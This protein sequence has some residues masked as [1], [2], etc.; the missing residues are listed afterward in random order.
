[1]D[2][3]GIP[4]GSLSLLGCLL[5]VLGA[6]GGNGTSDTSPTSASA[7]SH[8]SNEA[9]WRRLKEAR[10]AET[11]EFFGMTRCLRTPAGIPTWSHRKFEAPFL[12]V[13]MSLDRV[14]PPPGETIPWQATSLEEARTVVFFRYATEEEAGEYVP[15]NLGGLLGQTAGKP[16]AVSVTATFYDVREPRR[17][18]VIQAEGL[19]PKVIGGND[20]SSGAKTIV[21]GQEFNAWSGRDDLLKLALERVKGSPGDSDFDP[22]GE[23]F[24]RLAGNYHHPDAGRLAVTPDGQWFAAARQLGN[25]HIELFAATPDIDTRIG[26]AVYAAHGNRVGPSLA[27]TPDGSMLLTGVMGGQIQAYSLPDLKA[28]LLLLPVTT[29]L[30]RDGEVLTPEEWALTHTGSTR[31]LAVSPDGRLLA[32]SEQLYDHPFSIL[33]LWSMT[34]GTQLASWKADGMVWELVFDPSG[35][36]LVSAADQPASQDVPARTLLSIWSVPQGLVRLLSDRAE[37]I[38]FSLAVTLEDR[39]L[40]VG[41][42]RGVSIWSLDT[43]Q[44]V[45]RLAGASGPLAVTPKGDT[46]VCAAEGLKGIQ[47]WS[48][49]AGELV[50][51]FAPFEVQDGVGPVRALA[52]T[53]DGA[54]VMSAHYDT[55]TVESLIRE[56]Q[57][58]LL[59]WN[60][61]TGARKF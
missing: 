16:I 56:N 53:P 28:A 23:P 18:R 42:V 2:N 51:S 4:K 6:C 17:T 54:T 33:R 12:V 41:S 11:A 7:P 35:Q 3:H 60:A 31:A 1:M 38:V 14:D 36:T 50:R 58:E 44:E 22:P 52:I 26:S 21:D 32:S 48:L 57:G 46:L 15:M 9:E 59:L 27:I 8:A 39:R 45:G 20:G 5:V 43:G 47:L 61:A 55:Y 49:P 40:L 29:P 24:A 13:D 37:G 25:G 10:A 30:P 19:P 34:D